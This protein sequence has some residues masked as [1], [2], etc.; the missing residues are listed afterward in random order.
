M[1]I[2]TLT[3]TIL[4][5][6]IGITTIAARSTYDGKPGCKTPGEVG[7]LYRNFWD[8]MRYWR[9]IGLNMEPL[10]E[11]CSDGSGFQQSLGR[12]VAWRVWK[13]ELPHYPP[14]CPDGVMCISTE[15]L[16]TLTGETSPQQ[17]SLS[18][19][20]VM[21]EPWTPARPLPQIQPFMQ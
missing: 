1:Q 14:S 19:P 4:N 20:L 5:F 15:S 2:L 17:V 6:G 21:S 18:K 3:L 12:C 13:W 16:P 9:C 10:Q 11:S 7:H 8:P